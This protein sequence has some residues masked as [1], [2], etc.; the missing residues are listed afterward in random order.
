MIR[1]SAGS[2][3]R[4]PVDAWD[5]SDTIPLAKAIFGAD[6]DAIVRIAEAIWRVLKSR[7]GLHG[8]VIL[9]RNGGNNVMADEQPPTSVNREFTTQIV[10]AYVRRNQVAADVLP[11]LIS[12]VD[13]ALVT[14][15]TEP[16]DER[17]PAVPIRRSVQRDFVVCLD[18]GW[19]GQML[20]R[21]LA[22]AHRL[23]V[24]QYRARWS[25]SRDHA[26]TAPAYSERRST[27]A[28]QTGLGQRGRGSRITAAPK[29]ATPRR[30]SGRP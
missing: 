15:S 6:P 22:I 2:T 4:G 3:L 11:A 12:T 7:L 8:C 5:I 21:H 24:D 29:T 13:K 30:R 28:K 1:G 17:I 27:L 23:G 14:P 26:M 10:A 9:R 16:I 20:R 18:C 25:L 19:K